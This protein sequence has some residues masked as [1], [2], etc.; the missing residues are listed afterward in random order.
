MICLVASNVAKSRCAWLG[1]QQEIAAA[2]S[3]RKI[4]FIGGI[5]VRRGYAP[6]VQNQ[7]CHTIRFEGIR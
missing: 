4:D 6:L 1:A 2:C 5:R 3:V 7:R